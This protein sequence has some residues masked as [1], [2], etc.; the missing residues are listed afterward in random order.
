MT[1]YRTVHSPG[2][3]AEPPDAPPT[4]APVPFVAGDGAGPVT[5]ITISSTRCSQLEIDH[6]G[7]GNC[8]GDTTGKWELL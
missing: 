2:V 6:G 1:A 3:G 4:P 5:T 7:M 8:W